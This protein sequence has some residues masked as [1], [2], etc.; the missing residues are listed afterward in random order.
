[1]ISKYNAIPPIDIPDRVWPSKQIT[2]APNWCSVD[3]RDGNQAL[4]VPMN[5]ER[6]LE[7]FKLLVDIGFKE[8]EIGFPSAS[9][10][11]FEFTRK[12][13]EDGLIPDDVTVQ[14]LTQ[15]REYQIEKTFESLRGVDKTIVHLY[16]STSPAQREIVFR[17]TP[18]EIIEIAVKGAS[19][20]KES[21][22][23]FSGKIILEYSP[24]SF[25]QT[26]VEFSRDICDAVIDTWKPEGNEKVIINL[27][28]TVEV[29]SPNHFADQIEWMCRHLRNKNHSI[30]SV[31]THNDR[32][33]AVAAAELAQMAGAVRVE[34]T[35]F[36]NGERTGNV[37]LITLAMNLFSQG[38]DPE[39]DVFDFDKMAQI[40]RGSTGMA[41]SPRHPYI[42][43]LVFTAFSGSHQDAISK[44]LDEYQKKGGIWRV[45]YLQVDPKD[46]GR[47]YEGLI[48]INSQSGKGG[49]ARVL[50][51]RFGFHL[52]KVMHPEFGELVKTLADK[53]GRELSVNELGDCFT[54]TYIKQN[55]PLY[56]K[57]M[58]MD[59]KNDS[60]LVN[61]SVIRDDKEII[62]SGKGNGPIDAFVHGCGGVLGDFNVVEFDEH[63]LQKGSDAQAV[64]Y[65]QIE[66][67]SRL[68]FG[69][70]IDTDI[71]AASVKALISALNRSLT[72][73]ENLSTVYCR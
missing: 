28:S 63:S 7:M 6:K 61:V 34:G 54:N 48:R 64:A 39:I 37:D 52:P 18:D 70:G 31:H 46:V 38:I 71:S 67:N 21:A 16:N 4:V 56:F 72:E 73:K 29:T 22:H 42:G 17:K 13:I 49:A 27:P 55:G 2:H 41:I 35:L 23:E 11:E 36:G 53:Q 9:D 69:V 8:I 3:L 12:L 5:L 24:E 43:E 20:I 32:G 68:F 60:V 33:C 25:S 19:L 15:A 1:M 59:I 45:P 14:V 47:T 50:R 58:R 10:T 66:K 62:I 44:G 40:Y 65:L 30:I 26:E 57:K 51:D